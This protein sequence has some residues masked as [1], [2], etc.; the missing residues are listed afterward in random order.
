MSPHPLAVDVL[1]STKTVV[2]G[3]AS[4]M[5][6]MLLAAD[7]IVILGCRKFKRSLLFSGVCMCSESANKA[8]TDHLA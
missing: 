5:R 2:H 4:H 3:C 8:A 7:S 6:L 1:H